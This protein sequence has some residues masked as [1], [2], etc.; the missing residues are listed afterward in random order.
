MKK[1][2]IYILFYMYS[3]HGICQL[4]PILQ[5]LLNNIQVKKKN[6]LISLN[7]ETWGRWSLILYLHYFSCPTITC[8]GRARIL[9]DKESYSIKQHDWF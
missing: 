5:K 1:I 6:L 4:K 3:T 8:L 9:L 7:F 2:Q